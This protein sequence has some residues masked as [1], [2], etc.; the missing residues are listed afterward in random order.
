M[1]ARWS[2]G[3]ILALGA[4]G[5][6][7]KSRTSPVFLPHLRVSGPILC[8]PLTSFNRPGR[9]VGETQVAPRA[10]EVRTAA[11]RLDQPVKQSDS[12]SQPRWLGATRPKRTFLIFD[13]RGGSGEP[14]REECE[15]SRG[16][17]RR[18]CPLLALR[19]PRGPR[20]GGLVAPKASV[21]EIV[22]PGPSAPPPALQRSPPA[23]AP[24]SPS[25]ASSSGSPALAVARRPAK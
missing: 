21:P 10:S 3:M 19:R 16:P 23:R 24:R 14:S 4:R 2:R 22:A 8:L 7:F 15:Q 12:H 17:R 18:R 20:L 13:L 25:P 6:G 11:V 9:S 5:P 1:S